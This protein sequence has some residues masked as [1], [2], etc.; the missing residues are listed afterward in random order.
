MAVPIQDREADRVTRAVT[1]EAPADLVTMGVTSSELERESGM[2]KFWI[3]AGVI[4][5]VGL[6]VH[7]RQVS[8]STQNTYMPEQPVHAESDPQSSTTPTFGGYDCTDDCSGHQAGYDWAETH[9]IDD[10]DT[11]D[12]LDTNSES[13]KEGCKAFVNGDDRDAESEAG[14][15]SGDDMDQAS[16]A[17]TSDS[18][19]DEDNDDDSSSPD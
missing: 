9:D 14:I 1:I 5:A 3:A 2:Y 18:S 11:C 8:L 12:S 19:G 17:V 6:S 7:S 10:E 15:E 16:P 13:F 4:A